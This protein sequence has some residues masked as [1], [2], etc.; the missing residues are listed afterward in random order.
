[1]CFK[2]HASPTL[3]SCL[4]LPTKEASVHKEDAARSAADILSM[5]VRCAIGGRH[6]LAAARSVAGFKYPARLVVSV[7]SEARAD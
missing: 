2:G 1:M 5:L 7:V 3:E 6:A 4:V